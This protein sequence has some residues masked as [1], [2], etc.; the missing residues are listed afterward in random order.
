MPWIVIVVIGTGIVTALWT[1]RR[2]ALLV[3]VDGLSM[4][5]TLLHGQRVLVWRTRRRLVRVGRLAVLAPPESAARRRPLLVKRLVALPGEPVPDE[6]AAAP[7]LLDGRVPADGLFVVGDNR[8]GSSDSR[9]LG[10]FPLA[11][12]V[13]VVWFRVGVDPAIAP[14]Q[15]RDADRHA[16]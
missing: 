14:V 12:L 8:A 1:L 3:T 10:P 2:R 7:G 15:R 5:P 16:G 9:D 11:G 4:E 6:F 13:G